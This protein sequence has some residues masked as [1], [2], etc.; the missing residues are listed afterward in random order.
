MKNL[1]CQWNEINIYKGDIIL[2]DMNKE[3]KRFTNTVE[4]KIDTRKNV[5][6]WMWKGNPI[7]NL[8]HE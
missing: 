3:Y 2:I 5:A 6:Y 8:T 1:I 7:K 4:A